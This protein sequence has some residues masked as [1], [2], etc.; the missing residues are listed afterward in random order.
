MQIAPSNFVMF[1]NFSTLQILNQASQPQNSDRV[2]TTSQKYLFN[3]HQITTSGEKF[4]IIFTN[5]GKDKKYRTEFTKTR[6][7]E[8]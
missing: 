1:Q 2:F 5:E 7:F 3:V 6:H 4:S 8:Q